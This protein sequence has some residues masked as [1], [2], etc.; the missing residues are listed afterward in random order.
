MI[1]H[2][3]KPLIIYGNGA[4]ASVYASYLSSVYEIVA[5]SVEQSFCQTKY[6]EEKPLIPFESIEQAFDPGDYHFVVAVGYAEMNQVRARISA[7][8]KNK[9]YSMV[10]FV[11]PD[12]WRHAGVSIG[13]N[14]VI[15]DHCSLHCR[16]LVGNNVFIA[17][18]V[19]M[20]HDCQISD[21]VWINSGVVLAGGVSIGEGC[22]LGI[23][24]SVAHG[25]SLAAGTF[26]GANTLLTKNTKPNQVVVSHYGEVYPVDSHVYLSLLEGQRVS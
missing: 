24:A 17:S 3:K 23:N 2:H 25:V 8:I 15:L 7:F 19:Q 11:S 4:M 10:Q 16:S 6:F 20:G 21:N 14:T 1:I 13:E 26:V 18:G 5:F 22:F 9:G 12:L